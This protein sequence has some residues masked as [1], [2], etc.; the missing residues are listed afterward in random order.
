LL[1]DEQI[2]KIKEKTQWDE[3][4]RKWNLPPFQIKQKEISFPKLGNAKQFVREEL[5][6]HEVQFSND[7]RY[8]DNTTP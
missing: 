3:E 8:D 7:S 5:D 2:Y 4:R 1:N 6:N